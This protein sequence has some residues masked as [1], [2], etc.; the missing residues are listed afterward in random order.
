MDQG[1]RP[2]D[3]ELVG[4]FDLSH[5][6]FCIAGFDGYLKRANPAFARSLGY[7][8][9]ELLARP[10][11][12]NVYPDDLESVEAV[13]ADLAA[14]NDIVGFDCREVCAD[15]SVRWFEWTTSS[16]PEAGIV[17]GVARD[18]TDRRMA[19]DELSALR[20]VATL[21]AE[22]AEP[23]D[24]FALVA[25]E[26]AR[27]VNVPRVSVARY[28]LDGTATDC[29]SFP[30]GAPTSSV[31]KRWSLD[32]TN[33]LGLV[34]TAS[35]A[36][37]IDDYS[38]LD[39]QLAAT[40]RRIGIRSTVG[41]PIAVAGRLWGAMMVSTTAPDPL[42]GDTEARLA[43][44]TGLLATAIGNA[45]SREAL[46]RLADGQAALRRVATLVA[47]GANPSQVFSAVA[48]ELARVLDVRNAAVWRYEP[49]GAATLL[50]AHDTPAAKKMPVGMRFTL[51]GDNVAAMVLRTGAAARMD[52]HDHA[53]GSAA[54]QIRE[55]DLEGG[56]GAP[57]V[58]GGRLWGAAIVGTSRPEPLP[59][60]TEAR[61][62][63]FA[64]LVATAIGNA[65][66][67]ADLQASRDEL[68]VLAE[69]QAALRRVATLVARGVSP[70]EVFSAVAEELAHCMQASH[71]G[72][73]HYDADQCIA[74]ALY[75]ENRLRKLPEGLRLPLAGDNVAARVFRTRRP[76]RM[77]SHDN[78]PGAHAAR[79]REL[80][81]RS[82]VGVP[83]I[84]DGQLW[85][86]AVVG[87]TAPEPLPP[88]TEARMSDFADLVAT[89]I[90][91]AATRTELQES[92]DEL[93]VLAE[94][95]AALRRVA[96]LVARGTPPSEVFS[97]VADEMARCLH[98]ANATVSRFDDDTVTIVAV[99]A[100]TP[101]FKRA[102]VVGARH[103]LLEG[104][105]IAT[106][107]F[108]T[109]RP[110]RL[111]GLEFQNAPGWVAA[112]LR[113]TGLRSTVA[114]P[115]I[116]DGRVWGM[117]ALGSLRSEPL[118]PDTEAR[119]SDFA[120]LVATAIANAATRA[121][122]IASR[123][124][125]VAAADDGRRRLERDLHDGAQQRLVALGLQVR[126]AEAS[127]PPGLQALGEQLGDIVSGLTGVTTELQEISR[128]IH[129]SILSK[130]GIG[131]ALKALARRSAVPVIL[132]L[133]IDR[134]L[135]DSV[136]VGAYY[137]VSEALTNAAKHARASHVAVCGQ[138]KD[139]VLSLSISD[140][141]IGGADFGNGS[142]L[143]GLRDRVE[144]LGGRM[145]MAS[146]A[147]GGTSLDVSIP[148][149]NS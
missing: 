25:A 114:V 107:V 84:V 64:D 38:Q 133:A 18:V 67:R 117:A 58:V 146:P 119:M 110:A 45:E 66:T 29:A 116:V 142:G 35:K 13:L 49:D 60:D 135:P 82:A 120:D 28:E 90:A 15:G 12:A 56:V 41:V 87:S 21:V 30:P 70:S 9:D 81:V 2:V 93:G 75:H 68:S 54:A 5:D 109:G 27:V 94:Q 91:N 127:V 97:A 74:V 123:A 140:D 4:L 17:Y 16:R 37:R 73:S 131:P 85:G 98:A 69:Q 44:F 83:I 86:A 139:D 122:L 145:R 39:G 6:A 134:R 89:A 11:M 71:V 59:P 3:D 10:F 95:Q 76:A 124:R 8:L 61:I 40:V 112:W 65:A 125:I 63:D 50:A 77:D 48:T 130:G 149:D 88:D 80:G 31:G 115:I 78:A 137:V 129:P 62:A 113:K 52:S 121:E 42:P 19:N 43:N 108:H 47:R 148:F 53:A 132:E 1:G 33:A 79:I 36:S 22:E 147:G 51:E 57:I 141:G 26:V 92:R 103:T 99:A 144:A 101:G 20:R 143:I 14:G 23:R 24:L 55:L 96:T 46:G 34:R 100:L 104:D 118:P 102:P 72:V 106:R 128:G 105:N 136:E 7:T 138:A 111:D 126:L 32:G